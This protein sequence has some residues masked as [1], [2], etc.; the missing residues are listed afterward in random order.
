MSDESCKVIKKWERFF[1]IKES[2]T[3]VWEVRKPWPKPLRYSWDSMERVCFSQLSSFLGCSLKI[4]LLSTCRHFSE[5]LR[6]HHFCKY[7][8]EVLTSGTVYLADILFCE[9]ALFYFSEVNSAFPF[10]LC[11]LELPSFRI[12]NAGSLCIKKWHT[13]DESFLKWFIFNCF[14]GKSTS[15]AYLSD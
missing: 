8:I 6:S 1:Y 3:T 12:I 15:V 9:S 5:F 7:Q 14:H 10:I 11:L 4:S 13:R 2:G